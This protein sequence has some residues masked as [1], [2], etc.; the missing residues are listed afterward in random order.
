MAPRYLS[1]GDYE[2]RAV[3]KEQAAAR[4]EEA[5]RSAPRIARGD[6]SVYGY[7]ILYAVHPDGPNAPL[8]SP[9]TWVPHL[10][11]WTCFVESAQAADLENSARIIFN[12]SKG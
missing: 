11:A 4:R 6:S 7:E 8:P 3:R 9:W 2:D 1:R 5:L 12:I 10:K